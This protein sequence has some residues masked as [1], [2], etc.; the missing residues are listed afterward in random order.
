MDRQELDAFITHHQ[1]PSPAV[2]AAFDIVSAQPDAAET[3]RFL[4]QLLHIAGVL[5][6]AAGGVFFVAANWQDLRVFGRFALVEIPLLVSVA[7]ALWK[8]PPAITGRLALLLAFILSGALLALFGQTYQT[9]A[10][11][12]ELFFAWTLL[13]LPLIL[14]AHWSVTWA[15]WL[16]ILN[17]A[18]ALFSGTPTFGGWLGALFSSQW[19]MIERLVVQ[20]AV[21]LALWALCESLHQT[22]WHPIAAPWLGRL[23][24]AFAALAGTWAGVLATFPKQTLQSTSSGA[25]VVLCLLAA[26]TAVYVLRQRR[27]VFPIAMLVASGIVVSTCGIGVRGDFDDLRIYF[28]LASWLVG[29]SAVCG[30][31]LMKLV[32]DWKRTEAAA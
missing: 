3:R 26:A 9:G 18:L 20:V 4:L 24:F 22:R 15:A 16:L 21:N 10:D 32:R 8:P 12:Y 2:A 19:G 13:G 27:D 17:T 7:V 30:W 28:G 25:A 14:A 6:L 1:L 31:L 29:S 5:S 23:A 11:V